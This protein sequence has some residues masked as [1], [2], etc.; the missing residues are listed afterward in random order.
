MT[1]SLLLLALVASVACAPKNIPGTE[2]QDTPDTRALLMLMERFRSSL[3]AKDV[4]GLAALTAPT[5]QDEGG[6]PDPEDDLDSRH[7]EEQLRRRFARLQDIRVQL[8]VRKIEVDEKQNLA[9]VIYYYT[10]TYRPMAQG[11]KAERDSDLKQMVFVRPGL[12]E[13]WQI[14]SGI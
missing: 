4:K 5:V 3:E 10:V 13:E 11:G 1:R 12:K 9:K 7:L 8:D 14:A 2:L 6:P